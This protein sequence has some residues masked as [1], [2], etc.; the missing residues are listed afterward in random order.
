MTAPTLTRPEPKRDQYGRYLLPNPETGKEQAWTRATTVAGTLAD[1]FGLEKWG[2]RMAILGIAARPDLYALA[3]SCTDK[4][5][6]KERLNKIVEDAKEAAK[7]RS[8]ANLGTALHRILER[9]DS[10][11]E[12]DAPAA[13]QPDV[14]A[15]CSTLADNAVEVMPEYIERIVVVPKPKVAG[16]LDRLVMIDGLPVVAD[17]KTGED[18]VTY[19]M[20]DIA[21]QLAIYANASHMWN[22]NGYDPMPFVDKERAL[23][24]HLPVGEGRCDL[25]WVDI[26]A[27]KEAARLAFQVRDWR[28]RKGLAIPYRKGEEPLNQTFDE[29]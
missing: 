20:G 26:A 27:G 7:A 13:W 8:K 11:E 6:D 1:R 17:L 14:D 2:N 10:G 21:I 5:E 16:T 15:Y 9:I 28:K 12:L 4:E 23:V 22:G 29:W 19:G 18:V 24:I 3:A 25:Y